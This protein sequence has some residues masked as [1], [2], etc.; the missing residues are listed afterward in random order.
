[1]HNKKS[2]LFNNLFFGLL[3]IPSIVFPQ[4]LVEIGK[5]GTFQ[6]GTSFK[7]T[8]SGTFFILDKGT[9]EIIKMDSTG[10]VLKRIG[11]TGWDD[12]TFDN[13]ADIFVT[14]LKIYVTDRNN[15]RIQVYD[16]DLNF[17]FSLDPK[18]FTSAKGIFKYPSSAAV[19][20]F[21]DL[22]LGDTD[23][24]QIIKFNSNWDYVNTFAN[25]EY[26]RFAVSTPLKL[27]IDSNGN[28]FVLDGKR[29]L[30]FDQYGNGI[31]ITEL[32]EVPASIQFNNGRLLIL[33]SNYLYAAETGEDLRV[34]LKLEK[35]NFDFP[36]PVRDVLSHSNLF[37]FLTDNNII[38]SKPTPVE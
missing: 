32:K 38:I 3:F 8:E 22:F 16:A 26:G 31:S 35:I 17:L 4:K 1:M 15:S 21:G 24:K 11:G 33:Y 9:N 13:P 19:S 12:Y 27:N 10:N 5:I 14:L 30:V 36:S 37:Y 28:L 23:N 20:P 34:P 7:I 29:L 2:R 6:R 18:N 25:F